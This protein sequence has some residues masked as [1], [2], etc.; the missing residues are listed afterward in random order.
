MPDGRARGALRRLEAR[1]RALARLGAG[2][3]PRAT[4]APA[5]DR[6]PR[7]L[8]PP[9]RRTRSPAYELAV[10]QRADMIEIDLHRTRDG[11]IVVTHDEELAGLGGARRDR[12]RDARRGARAR[13][14]RRASG[15]RRSTELLDGFGAR[16]PFNLELKRGTRAEYAGLE[17]EALAA[18]GR[19]GSRARMLFSSVLRPGAARG[20]RGA[21]APEARIGLLISRRYPDGA[22]SARAPRSARRRS[23]RSGALVDAGR[24]SRQAH[25]RGPRRLRLHG[26]T[27][28][29]RWRGSSSSASTGSSPTSRTGCAALGRMPPRGSE[30]QVP[31]V[32]LDAMPAS[33]CRIHS[34]RE[35]PSPLMKFDEH[36]ARARSAST[37]AILEQLQENCKRPLAAIGEKVGLTAPSVLERIHKL[38]EAGV[39]RDYVAVLDARASRQGRR[40]PSSASR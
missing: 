28:R 21:L 20:L 24:S 29:R 11:A 22:S 35:A 4:G 8:G 3:E 36:G 19:A 37:S 17:A 9:A 15:C 40:P 18:L 7:R 26:A 25:A 16:I 1:R 6:A 10:A 23:I 34:V 13:R 33:G 12:R 2:T 27:S 38:E 39:I 32:P 30:P 31:S 5:R 14:R